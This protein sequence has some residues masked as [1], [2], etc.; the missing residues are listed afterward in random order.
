MFFIH[1]YCQIHTLVV[2]VCMWV[3]LSV[4]V[5][6]K[7]WWQLFSFILCTVLGRGRS[8]RSLPDRVYMYIYIYIYKKH[9]HQT[10]PHTLTHT[11]T[12]IH[13]THRFILKVQW[14][15]TVMRLTFGV[16]VWSYTVISVFCAFYIC[17]PFY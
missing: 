13:N 8:G 15:W 7:S 9:S 11:R 17:L 4:H 2:C 3:H 10:T 5:N 12:L 6:A 1:W 16:A 14:P